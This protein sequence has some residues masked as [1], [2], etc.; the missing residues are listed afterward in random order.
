MLSTQGRD[1]S[2]CALRKWAW[3][4]FALKKFGDDK[5]RGLRFLRNEP[6]AAVFYI[7]WLIVHQ[8]LK[9]NECEIWNG[10]GVNIIISFKC[11]FYMW[12]PRASNPSHHMFLGPLSNPLHYMK[13]FRRNLHAYDFKFVPRISGYLQVKEIRHWP[14]TGILNIDEHCRISFTFFLKSKNKLVW[15]W[16]P[17]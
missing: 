7:I 4:I 1:I 15:E 9:K 14:R 5:D 8:M 16:F 11:D 6:R 17:V 13:I 2:G 3:F 12:P 10:L